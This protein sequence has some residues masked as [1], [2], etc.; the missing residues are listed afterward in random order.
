MRVV[1]LKKK[2]KKN[3]EQITLKLCLT[4]L[5]EMKFW[6]RSWFRSS[7]R[8]SSSNNESHYVWSRR[9]GGQ[10]EQVTNEW[11]RNRLEVCWSHSLASALLDKHETFLC[12]FNAFGKHRVWTTRNSIACN[13]I[14]IYLLRDEDKKNRGLHAS[15]KVCSK[16]SRMQ[17][18]YLVIFLFFC[19]F[20]F[21]QKFSPINVFYNRSL[22]LL[23]IFT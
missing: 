15:K 23:K 18:C 22:V 6:C 17:R 12:H 3:V 16:K 2:K 1:W 5:I 14:R 11:E 13:S 19:T 4:I 20:D 10:S 9:S 8:G 7:S 21:Y